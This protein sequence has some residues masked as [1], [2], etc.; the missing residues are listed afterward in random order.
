MSYTEKPAI[1]PPS[2]TY[3]RYFAFLDLYFFMTFREIGPFPFY[4]EKKLKKQK[5]NQWYNKKD[6]STYVHPEYGK[7]EC[8]KTTACQGS[9]Q[10]GLRGYCDSQ[11]YDYTCCFN[12]PTAP[13]P[14]SCGLDAV[15]GKGVCLPQAQCPGGDVSSTPNLCE[16]GNSCCYSLQKSLD[17]YEFRGVWISTVA[18]IDWPSKKT[19][20]TAQ[21]QAELL[22]ILDIMQSLNINAV[23][24]QVRP[25]GDA[26]YASNIEPWSA[27]LTG[28]QGKA[29][30]PYWDPLD[31]IIKEGKARNIEVHAWLNPLRG[32]NKGETYAFASN[33]MTQLY[34]TVTYNYDGY[35]WMDP[36]S[37]QGIN[38]ILTKVTILK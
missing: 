24:F 38:F 12:K 15:R 27:Y 22:S 32:R 20:T 6:C 3:I 8:V 23:V 16:D 7:G 35:V 37:T 1:R 26:L 10:V 33:H 31:F 29:P 11:A 34:P 5:Y 4:Y 14:K 21:Q 17:Y 13:A 25:A 9:N 36:G 19:L 2:W 28:T 18:N 30:S